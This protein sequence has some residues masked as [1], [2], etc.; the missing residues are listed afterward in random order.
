MDARAL[1]AQQDAQVDGGP[2]RVSLAAVTALLVSRQTLDP[3]QD[4][5][6]SD[7][8]LPRFTGRV[9]AAGGR[10]G[11]PVE[12]L[13]TTKERYIGSYMVKCHIHVCVL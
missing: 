7:A 13:N 8:A 10:G 1:D 5:L 2:A 3:L 9:D 11:C 12:T 6:P 4:G